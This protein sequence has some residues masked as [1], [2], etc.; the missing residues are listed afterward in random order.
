[1]KRTFLYRVVVFCLAFPL[2]GAHAQ[3]MSHEEEFVRNTYA[4]VSFM[5]SLPPLVDA[6]IMQVSNIRITPEILANRVSQAT[7][8]FELSDFKV[9]PISDIADRTWGEF[10]TEPE[11]GTS[12][13]EA[14]I[15]NQDF[16]DNGN[17]TSWMM[18]RASW[19][20]ARR[21][22]PEAVKLMFSQPISEIV[23]MAEAQL[24]TPVNYTRYAA[25]TVNVTFQGKSTGPHKAIF[26]FGTD[27]RGKQFVSGND[28]MSGTDA[29]YYFANHPIKLSGLMLG[30]LR[31]TPA[32]GDW[33]RNNLAPASSC[34]P[35]AQGMCCAHGHCGVSPIEFNKDFSVPLP[36]PKNGGRP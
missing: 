33:L 25:F 13:L 21:E 24:N 30:K 20:A 2:L 11:P 3:N 19:A 15:T 4:K 26:F 36:A 14:Q 18:V 17:N 1:M 31:E 27:P 34:S 5:S 35:D 8:V 7:P 10:N 23:K 16:D 22:N 12:V 28:L 6:G 29:L 32:V 9:G